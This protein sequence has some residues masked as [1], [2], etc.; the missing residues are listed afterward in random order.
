MESTGLIEVA[1]DES[2][3]SV[4]LTS[5][6]LEAAQELSEGEPFQGLVT[7][8]RV[9]R[10]Q[11]GRKSGTALKKM[12]YR[13]FETEVARRDL[14]RAYL[15]PAAKLNIKELS[16]RTES[17][18][19]EGL[20]FVPGVNVL[21][22]VP[23]TGKTK[24]MSVLDYLMGEK[25]SV[26]EALGEDL[27]KKYVSA[28]CLLSVDGAEVLLERH[29][30]KYGARGAVFVNEAPIRVEDFDFAFLGMLGL[31]VLHYPQGNPYGPRTWP[32]LG[33]RSLLRHIYRRQYFWNVYRR[34]TA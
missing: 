32:R 4:T 17:G 31:P 11:L 8:M 27:A 21:V 22:G 29:W 10:K 1:H 33:W 15:M 24:W 20:R 9:V 13:E 16:R 23:N 34:Q 19:T 2:A 12:I 26:E 30:T 6:G 3:Y 5:A 14:G 28:S 25:G 7:H 18:A